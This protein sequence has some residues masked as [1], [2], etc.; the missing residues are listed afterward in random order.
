MD[1]LLEQ[2]GGDLPVGAH[3]G[4]VALQELRVHVEEE[5]RVGVMRGDGEVPGD[6]ERP[7]VVLAQQENVR[8]REH[9]QA[10]HF[11]RGRGNGC[12]HLLEHAGGGRERQ[13]ERVDAAVDVD[14]QHAGGGS[15]VPVREHQSHRG[16]V[17]PV[18]AVQTVRQQRRF[19][20]CM[21]TRGFISGLGGGFSGGIVGRL[22]RRLIR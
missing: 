8:G 4:L 2:I 14:S 6:G 7:A 19:C 16:V 22:T 10:V 1:D 3:G 9:A 21:L 13:R 12:S 18:H 17:Q 5:L 11:L 20:L 15:G